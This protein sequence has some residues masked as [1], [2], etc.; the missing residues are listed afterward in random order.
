MDEMTD[1]EKLEAIAE[2]L[3]FAGLSH[4]VLFQP[5]F[6]RV[7]PDEMEALRAVSRETRMIT[8]RAVLD[9]ITSWTT[10]PSI[11]APESRI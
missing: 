8:A 3:L 2:V 9:E 4:N 1:D 11:E 7:P 5:P 10:P 6:K